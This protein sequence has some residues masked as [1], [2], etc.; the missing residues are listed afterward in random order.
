[1]SKDEQ[2]KKEIAWR[3]KKV[4]GGKKPS[5]IKEELGGIVSAKAIWKYL[6][7]YSIPRADILIKISEVYDVTIDWLLRGDKS[8][9][10]KDT[11]EKEMIQKKR[12][13]EMLTNDSGHLKEIFKFIDFKIN[14]ISKTQMEMKKAKNIIPFKR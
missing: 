10:P 12:K 11:I 7:G 4:T 5:V 3:L 14:M 1:M 6:N 13:L 8:I 2:T 9:I